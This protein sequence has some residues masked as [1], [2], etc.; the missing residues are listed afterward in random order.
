M[1][2]R[3]TRGD[4]DET[5]RLPEVTVPPW[6]RTGPGPDPSRP[7]VPA[8]DRSAGA[9]GAGASR[10]DDRA[11]EPAREAPPTRITLGAG[12]G[13]GAG[14]GT[15]AGA[16]ADRTVGVEPADRTAGAEVDDLSTLPL[17]T[18]GAEVR[19]PVEE[20][21]QSPAVLDRRPVRIALL[22][23]AGVAVLGG[24]AVLG[25]VVTRGAVSPSEEAV[26]GCTEISEPGRVVGAGPGS[27]DT[28]AGAV[29]AFDH[30]YYVER[31]AEKAFEAVSPS[32]R[33]TEEQL[34]VEGVER[35]PEGT[36]HCVEARELSP[37]LLEVDLTEYP[38]ETDPVL[39]RQRVRLAENP[40]GTWGIVSITPAG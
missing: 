31:S 28:P 20:S 13:A 30:A 18:A 16:G 35:V 38:P 34:R 26:T 23:A 14:A 40:D 5:S 24:S 9:G 33:M 2:D 7:G 6:L 36:T 8:V 4:D 17:G 39:I 27:L 22:A 12:A 21:P 29:L 3:P 15:G 1:A 25:F 19:R 11:E 32:S 10:A 37:T